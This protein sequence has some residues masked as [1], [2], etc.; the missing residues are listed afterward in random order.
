MKV[1]EDIHYIEHPLSDISVGVVAIRGERLLF[2][3]SAT[4]GAVSETILPYLSKN[5]LYTTDQPVLV[6]NT[7]CHCD[8]IGGNAALK[9]MLG[10]TIAAHKADAPFIE[11]RKAQLVA[12]FGCFHDYKD[13]AIDQEFFFT[14]AGD[15]TP[16][17]QWLVDGDK[18]DVGKLMFEVL[19][20]PGHSDGSIVLYEPSQ[21]ILLA[22]DSIQGKGTSDTEVP[23]IVNLAAYCHSMRRLAEFD[24]SL[25]VAAHPFKPFQTAFFRGSAVNQFILESEAIANEYLDRVASLLVTSTG[26]IS[27]LELAT[28][29]SLELGLKQINRSL[30]M[31]TAACL[32]ELVIHG[33][34]QRLSGTRWHPE[35]LF[36]RIL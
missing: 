21:G 27:V 16:V 26:P 22:S 2:V 34:A 36:V 7:H 35:S 18:I 14:L 33:Q 19:H 20:T 13:L 11:S 31:L 30:V 32:D 25:L 24:I 28:Q 12:L 15:D 23:L 6:V 8:H 9:A 10:A 5:D 29:F 4:H 3:D 1:C 17:E